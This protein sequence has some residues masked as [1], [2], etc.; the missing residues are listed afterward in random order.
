MPDKRKQ[1]ATT[2]KVD[3]RALIARLSQQSQSLL[4]RE[5][6]AP[7]LPG[8]RIRTRL[9][10]LVYE[11]RARERFPG[12]GRFRPIS[13]R[14]AQFIEEALPWERGA[15]LELFPALRMLLLWPDSGG[16]FPGTWWALPYNE[17][18][19]RQRFGL[20]MEPMPVF[21]CDPMA[22]A[23]RF[24]RVIVRVDGGT[25]WFEGPDLRADPR[26]AEWL[27]EA[28]TME[29]E[30]LPE[31]LLPG[32]AASERLSLLLWR[33]HQLELAGNTP[34]KGLHPPQYRQ[35]QRNWLAGQARQRVLEEQ[36]RHALS[37]ADATLH[38]YSEVN[39]SDGSVRH[40]VVEWSEHGQQRRYRSLVDSQLTVVSSGI[41]LSGQDHDFDLT[42]LV[43]VMA[44]SPSWAAYDDEEDM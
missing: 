27:R 30:A 37:K 3:A 38:S 13:E 39:A 2:G 44:A 8:G 1:R 18:D 28:A 11:F 26:H 21:L 4:G 14:E 17:G 23:E 40:L 5:L 34:A 12:W 36:L 32:L 20:P 43:N 7:L 29:S 15:Y 10:G 31:N 24:E 9:N 42:S 6:I 41:C 22:G 35:E 33:I 19:A 16:L 25:R